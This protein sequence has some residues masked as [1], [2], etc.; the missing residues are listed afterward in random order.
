MRGSTGTSVRKVGET[1]I[2]YAASKQQR[3]GSS[4]DRA[5]ELCR[6]ARRGER[7]ERARDAVGEG[8]HGFGERG[9]GGGG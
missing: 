3:A 6:A 4:C 7:G 9:G 2:V 8:N 1:T 5:V